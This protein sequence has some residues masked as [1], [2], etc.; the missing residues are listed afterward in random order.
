MSKPQ[1]EL[2]AGLGWRVGG[3]WV[4]GVASGLMFVGWC[5]GGCLCVCGL[6]WCV[7]NGGLVDELNESVVVLMG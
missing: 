6:G 1:V 5:V 4:G 2:V 3:S 7:D